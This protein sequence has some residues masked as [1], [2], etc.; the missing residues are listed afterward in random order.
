MMTNVVQEERSVDGT[1]PDFTTEETYEEDTTKNKI[2]QRGVARFKTTLSK[3][4]SYLLHT[5]IYHEYLGM[6]LVK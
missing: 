6:A 1:T 2:L 5:S 3:L 4:Y